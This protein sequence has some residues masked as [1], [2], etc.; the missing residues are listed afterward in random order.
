[1]KKLLSVFVAFIAFVIVSC[2]PDFAMGYN[3]KDSI[4]YEFSLWKLC[5]VNIFY[6]DVNPSS[7]TVISDTPLTRAEIDSV[8]AKQRYTSGYYYASDVTLNGNYI[9]DENGEQRAFITYE[10]GYSYPCVIPA[11]HVNNK[12]GSTTYI[13][14]QKDNGSYVADT[15]VATYHYAKEGDSWIYEE[16]KMVLNGNLVWSRGASDVGV[17]IQ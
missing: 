9:V 12:G 6:T 15:L 13:Y 3:W 10:G 5:R 17:V 7:S 2:S 14:N 1:M 11:T 16:T 8:V 4:D